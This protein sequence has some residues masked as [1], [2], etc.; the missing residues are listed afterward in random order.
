MHLR[1]PMVFLA[2]VPLRRAARAAEWQ[3]PSAGRS[4]GTGGLLYSPC[5]P[6]HAIARVLRCAG[7]LSCCSARRCCHRMHR[8]RNSSRF[9]PI[10]FSTATTPNSAIRSAKARPSSARPL[11]V[12]AEI[13]LNDRVTLSAGGFAN[14]RFGSEAAFEQVRPVL[15]LTVRGTAIGVRLRDA[16]ATHERSPCGA[17][18]QWSPC[19]APAAPA[20]DARLRSSIR[21]RSRMDV[22]R[23]RSSASLLARMAAPQHP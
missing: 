16:S 11:R 4:V 14:Q 17:R 10:S 15:S 20:R 19:V 13:A 6:A 23:Q 21:N 3:T 7:R 8:R 1:A 5:P 9:D 12:T 18:P 22:Q 2:R